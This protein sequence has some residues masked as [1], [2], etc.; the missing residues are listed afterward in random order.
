MEVGY[1]RVR[2]VLYRGLTK[3]LLNGLGPKG[4]LGYVTRITDSLIDKEINSR[5]P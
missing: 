2:S 5:I 4:S 1:V 3:D